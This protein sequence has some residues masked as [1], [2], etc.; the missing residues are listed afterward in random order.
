METEFIPGLELS[1]R[2]YKEAVRPLLDEHF[3]HL[4][5][6]AALIGY[7][8]EVLGFDTVR[9][10]DHDWG[11][12]TLLFLP[13]EN[14]AGQSDRMRAILKK[15]LPVEF[16]GYPVTPKNK[17]RD[18][19]GVQVFTLQ[20]FVQGYLGFDIHRPI[21]PADW[22][23]FPE[24]KLLGLTSGAVFWDELGLEDLRRRFEYYPEDVWLY[25]L[26]AGWKR[27]GQEESLMGRAGQAGDELGSALIAARLVR[28]LMRLWFLMNKRYAPYSKWFGTAFSRLPETEG[29]SL[30]FQ[31]VLRAETWTER[32]EALAQA[33]E[34]TAAKHNSLKIT[35]PLA[36]KRSYFFDRP[37]LVIGG[38][39]FSQAI[40]AQITDPVVKNWT[41]D[42]RLIGGIDQFS[43]STDILA[44]TRWR[45]ILKK[46]YEQ[47]Q[48]VDL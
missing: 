17:T 3:P 19:V 34:V 23:T 41:G 28:D 25:L 11:P 32:Q 14:Y 35:P 10:T 2:F 39:E 44:D 5:H 7:G 47:D 21:E 13:E 38:R 29:L 9:S 1:R 20:G 42:D 18:S 6:A 16:S 45:G 33:Y 12:R 24:Q 4:K 22:L 40:Q 43:D 46:L 15:E 31:K 37:F 8:S 27:I 30:L 36:E 48:A 26:A